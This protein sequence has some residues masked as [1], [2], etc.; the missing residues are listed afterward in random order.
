MAS[1]TTKVKI[2]VEAETAKATKGLESIG[3]AQTRLGQA[4][5]SAGRQFSSQASGLG[6]LVSAY[7][8]AAANIFAITMA[9]SALSR[10]A[11]AEQTIAGTRALAAEIG[12]SGDEIIAKVQEITRGQLTIGEAAQNANI[13]LSAGFD[14]GQFEQLTEVAL[15]ASIALGRNLPDALTRL[16]RGTAKIE[17]EILD[18][19]GIFIRLDTAVAKY[20]DR[21]GRSAGSLT[22][23]ERS[24]AFL[25]A[26]LEQGQQKFSA[27]DPTIEGSVA[28]FERLGAQIQDLGQKFGAILAQF[29]VPF[30]DF[31]SGNFTNTLAAFGLLSGVI[32]SKLGQ[33]VQQ[34]VASATLAITAFGERISTKLQSSAL[35]GSA[36]LDGLNKEL[37]GL[38][39]RTVKG[40]RAVQKETRELIN[41]GKAGT[42]TTVQL[43]K[44]QKVLAYQTSKGMPGAAAAARATTLALKQT[45]TVALF[46]A[47]AFTVL[48][49][50]AAIAGKLITGAFRFL[51][52]FAIVLSSLE[53]VSS[54]VAKI[55]GVDLFKDIG[56]DISKFFTDYSKNVKAAEEAAVAAERSIMKLSDAFKQQQ[57]ILDKFG[58][59]T[60]KK[61]WF[62]QSDVS[63]NEILKG[64]KDRMKAL[65]EEK[66]VRHNL[67]Q[68]VK[69]PGMRGGTPFELSDADITKSAYAVVKSLDQNIPENIRGAILTMLLATPKQSI[70]NEE[71]NKLLEGMYRAVQ[72]E[73]GTGGLLLESAITINKGATAYTL[74]E[75]FTEAIKE[76]TK[77]FDIEPVDLARIFSVEEVTKD[78]GIG[79]FQA[80]FKQ[81]ID[82]A[83]TGGLS[84]SNAAKKLKGL[85]DI[86]ATISRDLQA[87][88]MQKYFMGFLEGAD[89]IAKTIS[90]IELLQKAFTAT[91]GSATKAG[92]V[93]GR[94]VDQ[95]TLK[96]NVKL[97]FREEDIRRNNLKILTETAQ[98]ISKTAKGDEL[99]RAALDAIVGSYQKIGKAVDKME[100]SLDKQERKLKSQ[101]DIL[102]L[103]VALQDDQ[104]A[105]KIKKAEN[106]EIDNILKSQLAKYKSEYDIM[107]ARLDLQK[108]SK[109]LAITEANIREEALNRDISS[110][111]RETAIYEE[112]RNR[113][114]D[115][116]IAGLNQQQIVMGALPGLFTEG[117]GRQI[118]IQ[119]AQENVDAL[120]D[121]FNKQESALKEFEN[122]QEEIVTE[123]QAIALLEFE[124]ARDQIKH[125]KSIL[126]FQNVDRDLEIKRAKTRLMEIEKEKISREGILKA[127]EALALRQN[128]T[129]QEE[130][131]AAL[132]LQ[133]LKFDLIAEEAKVLKAHPEAVAMALDAHIA[134]LKQVIPG[135][136]DV[137]TK[138]SIGAV[139]G[140]AA[141][142]PLLDAIAKLQGRIGDTSG[143]GPGGLAATGL[144]AI[145]EELGRV[146]A[147]RAKKARK[148]AERLLDTEVK[149]SKRVQDDLILRKKS[150][151]DINSIVIQRLDLELKKNEA[152]LTSKQTEITEAASEALQD[153][154]ATLRA[155]RD[156]LVAASNDLLNKSINDR[157]KSDKLLQAAQKIAVQVGD[158]LGGSITDLFTAMR[159]GTLTA[160][161][162]KEGLQDLFLGLLADIQQTVL[163]EFVI[164]P[165]K[166]A[167]KEL[168]FGAAA[169][170]IDSTIGSAGA[171]AYIRVKEI[172]PVKSKITPDGTKAAVSN[173]DP[174]AISASIAAVDDGLAEITP[175]L[176]WF[177][178]MAKNGGDDITSAGDLIS[179]GFDGILNNTGSFSSNLGNIFQGAF[180]G[181]VGIGKSVLGGLGSALF[182][183]GTESGGLLGGIFSFFSGSASGGIVQQ[184]MAAGGQLRD[185]VPALL[186][187][188][189]FVIRR[190]MAKA[191]GG[192]ALHAMNSTGARPMPKIDVVINNEG[193]PKD[194]QAN[195][196]PQIDID[197]L[198]VEI[199]TRDVRNNG[200]IRKTLRGER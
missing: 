147:E 169:P 175:K 109:D 102:K 164:N 92:R 112:Q 97:L 37:D 148:S 67:T 105:L 98:A 7:A 199:V 125:Q 2:K 108:A 21:I 41:L 83:N 161:N 54:A 18:E 28:S 158:R 196:K 197:K 31:I 162:F 127:Q 61:W 87:K 23:F 94:F 84:A 173:A 180:Q 40:A 176:G 132:K 137:V 47:K 135:A 29:L 51:G 55:F 66:K 122:K 166:D 101:L 33:V 79:A 70:I 20:A 186:E 143:G 107:K 64:S 106:K 154:Q 69:R 194:A 5:A 100:K 159:E 116:A 9:F 22:Q 62:F 8:G 179:Q 139:G 26:A 81:F 53:L 165:L 170:K 68:P 138:T 49:R 103:Q 36:A 93:I 72:K 13:A 195:V 99:R 144:F 146:N 12:K 48:G 136:K 65:L 177:G 38:N 96:G 76:A 14:T 74:N 71:A 126:A 128:E 193:T 141:I 59:Y 35:Q 157:L 123:Q 30:A 187:P 111:E 152:L 91:F 78:T 189:E 4:S 6:G 43:I 56:D 19:L 117:Q 11:Q 134:A 88:S 42:L 39:L 90:A 25:T 145:Q 163:E 119:I 183:S 178:Q 95:D 3:R 124:I 110:R 34:K 104:A 32:F 153:K 60:L 184:K 167:V 58:D 118:E 192:P 174:E 185:R 181:I 131:I 200:P 63:M 24:Q 160:Q 75:Q 133:K 149:G 50:A 15:K 77:Q 140:S 27:I 86:A 1:K 10:A 168:F 45:G 155:A 115:A 46:A 188:G 190:P 57:S 156:E 82:A 171:S 191:I 142:K 130:A 113:Q 129:R 114:R 150:E 151:M 52:I 73:T 44:L 182:G 80:Q 16:T 172:N 121:I 85:R 17:P 198:V 120:R 89:R